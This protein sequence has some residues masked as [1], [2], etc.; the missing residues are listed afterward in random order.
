MENFNY[1]DTQFN[2]Y[3]ILKY[4][5]KG[6]DKLSLNQKQYIYW[7][8]KATEVGKF[9]TMDQRGKYNVKIFNICMELSKT[10][11]D[12]KLKDYIRKIWFNNGIYDHYTSIKIIPSFDKQW[13][14]DKL[15][16]NNIN[17]T[18]EITDFIFDINNMKKCVDK[19]DETDVLKKSGC[20]FYKNLTQ[21]E[22]IDYYKGKDSDKGLN[23]FL[24]KDNGKIHEYTYSYDNPIE[25]YRPYMIYIYNIIEYLDEAK[26]YCE[27]DIQ[28]SLLYLLKKYYCSGDIS[29]FNEYNKIW[30]KEIYGDVDFIN[31]FIETYGDPLSIKGT[32]EGFV[33]I[34][35]TENTKIA[36]TVANNAQWFEDHS[37]VDTKYKKEKCKGIVGKAVTACM[38]GGEL[39]PTTAIGINLPNNEKIRE[40]F[41]S[42]SVTITN[43]IESYNESSNSSI[44]DEFAEEEMKE[45]LKKY[46]A[47]TSQIHVYLHECVGHGSGKL[48]PG[49]NRSS[50]KNYSSTIEEARA[51]LFGLYF[52]TD[53]KMV[54]LGI[55]PEGNRSQKVQYYHYIMDAFL[56]QLNKV[57]LGEKIEED[58]M[59]NRYLITN[60]LLKQG[61]YKLITKNNKTYIHI[62]D[63][64]FMRDKIGE[65]LSII[66]KI[67]SEGDFESAKDLVETYGINPDNNIHNEII[68]RFKSLKLASHKGFVN[69]TYNGVRNKDNYIID[70]KVNYSESYD[71]QISRMYIQYYKE[72]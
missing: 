69:P 6:F 30:V 50:L 1:I 7:L 29:Y 58:H 10:I 2:D 60:W 67:K 37:P 39:Y 34:K 56:V 24:E 17:I 53:N 16:E 22:V 43:I 64:G 51:D 44:I 33:N 38:L 72:I 42:K 71:D 23:T 52:I 14:K 5:V 15:S 13:F 48:N 57:K 20:N 32:W 70:I 27:N 46:S 61:C 62:D 18:D 66:Q 11:K 63:Y 54:E 49:I 8:S 45:D 12:D 55:M 26:K 36:E 31:G 3:I 68:E 9:L 21:K 47:L 40:D 28:R 4:K 65:L 59:R 35:D 41:G 25:R 19:S